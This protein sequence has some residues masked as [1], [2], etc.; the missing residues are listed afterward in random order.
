MRIYVCHHEEDYTPRVVTRFTFQPHADTIFV[1]STDPMTV[2]LDGDDVTVVVSG[3]TVVDAVS[4][5]E[6]RDCDGA[7]FA[8]AADTKA[9]IDA[10]APQDRTHA[11]GQLSQTGV[12]TTVISGTNTPVKCAGTTELLA[13]ENVSMPANNRLRYDGDVVVTAEVFCTVQADPAGVGSNTFTFRLYRDGE[14]VPGAHTKCRITGGANTATVSLASLVENLE[15]GSYIE[16]WVE[17]NTNGDDISL[18]DYV[19]IFSGAHVE[20]S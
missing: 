17:N 13:A 16:L 10:V 6:F 11:H 8:S 3:R 20:P 2:T 4:F 1:P 15:P 12:A 7:P 19:L 14:P 5:V 9:Y 18:L